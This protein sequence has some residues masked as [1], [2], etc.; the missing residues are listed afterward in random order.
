MSQ[1]EG[2]RSQNSDFVDGKVKVNVKV[3]KAED[4]K[5]EGKDSN[6]LCPFV[7]VKLGSDELQKHKTDVV[8][9]DP[10]PEWNETFTFKVDDLET[11]LIYVEVK[12]KDKLKS[13]P[14]SKQLKISFLS[15]QYGETKEI[16]KE[17]HYKDQDVGTLYL[18]ISLQDEP[19]KKSGGL[20]SPRKGKGEGLCFRV[21][22][23]D[24]SDLEEGDYCVQL[25]MEVDDTSNPIT[26][27][28]NGTN[29]VWNE[30]LYIKTVDASKDTLKVVLLKNE[31]KYIKSVKFPTSSFSAGQKDVTFDDDVYNTKNQKVGH[32]RLSITP[33]DYNTPISDDSKYDL[34]VYLIDCDGYAEEDEPLTCEL[35]VNN[36]TYATSKGSKNFKWNQ[37]LVVPFNNLQKDVFTIKP[38]KGDNIAIFL[39]ELEMNKTKEYKEEVPGTD[40]CV[41][42]FTLR[43]TDHVRARSSY[44]C[45]DFSLGSDLSSHYSTS[46]TS[47]SSSEL[48]SLS[49]LREEEIQQHK[50]HKP[51]EQRDTK[52][53]PCRYDNVI[54]SLKSLS[55][56]VDIDDEDGQVYVTMDLISYGLNKKKKTTESN[57]VDN[58]ET[59]DLKF[60]LN[61][62][63]KGN[64][65]VFNIWK[66][67]S[68]GEPA[69]I[70]VVEIPVKDIPDGEN[71]V[72]H[73][74]QK[75]KNF[76]YGKKKSFGQAVF[77]INHT[78]DYAL[79]YDTEDSE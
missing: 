70:G 21:K 43:P 57:K 1:A 75:P 31:K 5:C 51:D 13:F 35:E 16:K 22:A 55:D 67:V 66:T 6:K 33:L 52:V 71:D 29:P 61:R 41:I 8:K 23:I 78:T 47:L 76:A 20:K 69:N 30:D 24:A 26:T 59:P 58:G 48:Q 39:K 19:R 62:I 40:D 3:I 79:P 49:S 50:Q 77:N 32:L 74:I 45:H 64:V 42:H 46:F 15:F 12:S 27:V 34:N 73:D 60:Y 65:L 53:K 37:S 44:D 56:L 9:N 38:S 18:E 28:Q 25:K 14:I 17:L 2:I 36:R 7:S 68:D 4:L 63:K 54:G 11:E 10:N 72:T